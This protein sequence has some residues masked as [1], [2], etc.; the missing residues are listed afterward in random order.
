MASS[1]SSYLPFPVV[2][3]L[4][5][6][7]NYNNTGSLTG[8]ALNDYNLAKLCLRNTALAIAGYVVYSNFAE[9]LGAGLIPLAFVSCRLSLGA[10]ALGASSYFTVTSAFGLV[11]A[12]RKRDVPGIAKNLALTVFA[13]LGTT[14]KLDQWMNKYTVKPLMTPPPKTNNA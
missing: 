11:E 1:L 2:S 5:V 10:T 14:V 8:D 6:L 3:A 4:Y 7:K 9:Q 12:A 13:Y